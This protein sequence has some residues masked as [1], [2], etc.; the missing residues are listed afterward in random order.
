[1]H[2]I[3]WL[4]NKLID[5]RN[6]HTTIYQVDSFLDEVNVHNNVHKMLVS[7]GTQHE[8]NSQTA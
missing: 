3:K 1:M 8:N 2:E 4:Y 5:Y 6:S 7:N